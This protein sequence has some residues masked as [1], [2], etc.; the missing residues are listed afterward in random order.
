MLVSGEGM[1]PRL[2]FVRNLVEF[3]PILPHSVGEEAE[4]VVRNPC[5]FPIEFYSLEFDKQYLYEEKVR[6][7]FITQQ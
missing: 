3:K 1:E 4:V 6:L 2:D 5:P 7:R